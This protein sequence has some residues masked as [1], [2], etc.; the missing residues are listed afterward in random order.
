MVGGLLKPF[1]PCDR[2]RKAFPSLKG[3]RGGQSD[4][5]P[6]SILPEVWPVTSFLPPTTFPFSV[7]WEGLMCHPPPPPPIRDPSAYK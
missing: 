6:E 1:S 2:R 7:G 4:K 5:L 3:Q